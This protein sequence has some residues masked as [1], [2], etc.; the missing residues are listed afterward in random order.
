MF[1]EQILPQ[2]AVHL[3]FSTLHTIQYKLLDIAILSVP[4]DLH[5]TTNFLVVTVASIMNLWH[6][7]ITEI[8]SN[9][10]DRNPCWETKQCSDNQ[11]ISRLLCNLSLLRVHK[12]PTLTQTNLRHTHYHHMNFIWK[13]ML[14]S[15]VRNRP[16]WLNFPSFLSLLSW[17]FNDTVNI[18]LIWRWR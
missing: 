17:L 1:Q 4:S 18:E 8:I 2:F 13:I 14:S 10:M 11:E 6:M 16:E 9:S 3:V 7:N 12:T 5:K 15:E